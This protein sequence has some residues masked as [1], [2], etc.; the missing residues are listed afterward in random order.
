V[1]VPPEQNEWLARESQARS[2]DRSA[3]VREVFED[4]RTCFGLPPA[5]RDLLEQEAARQRLDLRRFIGE[6]LRE[7]V[8]ELRA[9]RSSVPPD[10]GPG[11]ICTGAP[12]TGRPQ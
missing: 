5:D 7:T 8:R 6:V 3:F 11:S 9:E 12:S 10:I 1:R 4:A 2:L